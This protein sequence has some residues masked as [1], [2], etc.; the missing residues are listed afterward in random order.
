M[1]HHA[2][3]E[4]HLINLCYPVVLLTLPATFAPGC[5]VAATHDVALREHLRFT[6]D[7]MWLYFA[8]SI[9]I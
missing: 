9:G 4:I 3:I 2:V 5:C 6:G 8:S 1:D 7:L